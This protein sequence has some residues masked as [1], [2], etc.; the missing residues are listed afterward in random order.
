VPDVA[1]FYKILLAHPD[2]KNAEALQR[3]AIA[4]RRIQSILDRETVAHQKT[5]EQKIAEQG[6]RDLRVEPNAPEVLRKEVERC[7]SDEGRIAVLQ[8]GKSKQ[9]GFGLTSSDKAQNALIYG[10][11]APIE[12]RYKDL[13]SRS[14]T[15]E[16]SLIVKG[17]YFAGSGWG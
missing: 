11:S 12:I 17:S 14:Y 3:I 10:A 2:A 4:K 13:R 9:N 7:F 16:L 6:P 15:S 1:D 8:P 5:L